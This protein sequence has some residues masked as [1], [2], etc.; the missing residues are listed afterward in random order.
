[1]ERLDKV[2]MHNLKQSVILQHHSLHNN[3]LTSI[4]QIVHTK[5]MIQIFF[6]VLWPWKRKKKCTSFFLGREKREFGRACVSFLYW[7]EGKE[8]CK[9]WVAFLSIGIV[10]LSVSP[11]SRILTLLLRYSLHFDQK[12][13]FGYILIG[14]KTLLRIK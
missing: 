3:M 14:P 4:N 1:M 12:P 13:H 2:C 7:R 10:C 11:I 6:Q 5:Y 8:A 9:G